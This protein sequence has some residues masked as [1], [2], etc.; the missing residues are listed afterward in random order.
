MELVT[1][2]AEAGRLALAIAGAPVVGF[3]CEFLSQDRL[4]PQLCLLQ[5][6]YEDASGPQVALVDALAVDVRPLALALQEHPLPVAHAPRQD[7]QLLAARFQISMPRVF[8]PQTAAAFLGLGDQVGYSRLVAELLGVELTK[9]SQWTDWAAR[10]LSPAQL[11]YACSDV[12][13]L[14]PLHRELVSRLGPRLGW[15]AAECQRLA[16]VARAAAEVREEDAWEDVAG[17]GGLTPRATSAVMA[18]AAW[19]LATARLLDKPLGHVLTDKVLVELA[20]RP[21]RDVS[22]LRRRCESATGRER[23]EELFAALQDS[24]R[25]LAPARGHRGQPRRRAEA[26]VPGL[27]L[28]VDSVAAR[29]RIAPRLLATRAEGES[30]ARAFDEGGAAGAAGHPAMLGWRR[31]LLGDLCAGWMAGELA[32][33]TSG[34]GVELVDGGDVVRVEPRAGRPGRAG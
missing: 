29:E 10:P 23:A 24:E 33:V 6:C 30:L 15:V 18:L 21:P 31:E 1:D 2:A 3:D 20:R 8:D 4:I 19:R 12:L 27:L 22:A 7:L 32:I 5:L 9:D 25:R 17:S 14:L 28:I 16:E 26:W 11:R 13:H 34:S